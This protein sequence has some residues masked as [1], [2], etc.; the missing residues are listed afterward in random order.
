MVFVNDGAG[1]FSQTNYS[2]GG[3]LALADFN[4]DGLE[5]IASGHS[6][7]VQVVLNAGG[8][9]LRAPLSLTSMVGPARRATSGSASE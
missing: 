8:G 5:D 3:P 9:A 2:V 4:G 6:E 7:G 1:A